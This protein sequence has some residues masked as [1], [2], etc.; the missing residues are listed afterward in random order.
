MFLSLLPRC[1]ERAGAVRR[2][3]EVLG[4]RGHTDSLGQFDIPDAFGAVCVSRPRTH[5][6]THRYMHSNILINFQGFVDI[7][8]CQVSLSKDACVCRVL[9]HIHTPSYKYT[10]PLK[11]REMQV[12]LNNNNLYVKVK[13]IKL[14]E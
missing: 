12:R 14:L 7:L 9:F 8:N 4:S 13:I 1:P 3:F 2:T 11:T 5:I 6:H 10:S